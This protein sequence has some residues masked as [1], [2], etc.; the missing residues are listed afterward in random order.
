MYCDGVGRDNVLCALAYCT[1]ACCKVA[2][3][4]VA[5]SPHAMLVLFPH[6]CHFLFLNDLTKRAGSKWWSYGVIDKKVLH[7]SSLPVPSRSFEHFL[8]VAVRPTAV[9][10]RSDAGNLNENW[11]WIPLPSKDMSCM[12]K[13][14][15]KVMSLRNWKTWTNSKLSRN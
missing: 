9:Q 14:L 15:R 3:F 11:T 1:A 2:Y 12:T 10:W 13:G 7:Q 4:N 5:S 6:I 8:L